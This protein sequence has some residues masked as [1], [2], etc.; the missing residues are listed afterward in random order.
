MPP[1]ENNQGGEGAG[2]TGA[3]DPPFP[4][5]NTGPYVWV[6]MEV[7]GM[8]FVEVRRD[9]AVAAVSLNKPPVNALDA[10][11]LRE[12][13]AAVAAL[14]HDASVRAVL[15]RSAVPGIFIA[16][17]DIKAFQQP[18]ATQ[19]ALT[20]FHDCFNRIERLPKPTV[21]AIT[22]HALGGGCEFALVCDFRLM[23]D[24]GKSTIGLPEVSLGIFP[25]AGGTQRLP[26]IVGRARALDI[27]VH[28]RRLTAPEAA[29]WGLVH[30]AIP[31][32]GFEE[33]VME[34]A[35]RL[36]A[37]PTRALAAAKALINRAFDEPLA[38]GLAAEARK[39][40]AVL[41]TEDAR[42]GV[43]AFLEKRPPTFVGR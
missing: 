30:E 4:L 20:A 9:G 18:E 13:D 37:G 19:A 21:A 33:R 27:I 39:F 10:A 38:G 3:P 17:A 11:F 26:R 1:A 36:A 8:S 5:G 29:A 16:G 40:V 2:F 22:G 42:E 15:F 35:V 14:E 28:G 7:A 24:D 6:N 41:D 12:I 43:R 23:I 25:G 32:D 34:Y 31:A